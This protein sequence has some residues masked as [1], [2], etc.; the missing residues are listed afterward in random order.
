MSTPKSSASMN[1]HMT[2]I[3]DFD[4]DAYMRP[5]DDSWIETHPNG[6]KTVH[7]NHPFKQEPVTRQGEMKAT[8]RLFEGSNGLE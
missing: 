3:T 2:G 8:G 5:L 1:C 4:Y 6:M 7:G